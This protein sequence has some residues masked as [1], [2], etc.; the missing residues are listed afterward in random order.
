MHLTR[1]WT[2]TT[3]M[4]VSKRYKAADDAIGAS[5]W[6][7]DFLVTDRILRLRCVSLRAKLR[8]LL[9]QLGDLVAAIGFVVASEQH[10]SADEHHREARECRK[11]RNDRQQANDGH[12]GS[13]LRLD[14]GT[15]LAGR[16]G[17]AAARIRRSAEVDRDFVPSGARCALA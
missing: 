2:R 1:R 10:P 4:A 17:R 13:S 6:G 12:S 15:S 7:R 9:L 5:R 16:A 11:V 14:R 8:D 3:L